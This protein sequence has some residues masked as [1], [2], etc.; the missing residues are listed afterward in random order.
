MLVKC[1]KHGSQE[2]TTVCQHIAQ[3]LATRTRVGFFSSVG[4]PEVARPDA[5]CFDCNERVKASNGEW[6]G[7]VLEL[8]KPQVLCASCYD[9]AKKF[10]MGGDL[11]N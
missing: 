4:P 5:C 6:I 3:G 8:A 7:E 2:S 9:L 10:H 11:W 1:E